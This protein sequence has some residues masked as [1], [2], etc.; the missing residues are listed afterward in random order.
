MWYSPDNAFSNPT[1]TNHDMFANTMDS[2]L[3]KTLMLE[4]IP[5]CGVIPTTS[6]IAKN[7]F[8]V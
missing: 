3:V 5:P 6:C 7:S 1:H 2:K 8:N 4:Q